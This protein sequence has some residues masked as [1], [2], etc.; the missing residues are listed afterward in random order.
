MYINRISM[1]GGMQQVNSQNFAQEVSNAKGL[2]VVDFWA[3]WCVP[4]KRYGPIF[5]D[6]AKSHHGKAKFLKLNVEEAEDVA[7]ELGVQS[8]PTTIFFKDGEVLE[9]VPGLM[10][11]DQLSLM[12]EQHH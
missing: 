9:Q 7:A 5:E 10:S 8:I 6:V 3:E 4:C 11:K 12:V 2:V 1:A